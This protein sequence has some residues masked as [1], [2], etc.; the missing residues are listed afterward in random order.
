MTIRVL[1]W[2]TTPPRLPVSEA[3]ACPLNVVADTIMP[4][5]EFGGDDHWCGDR[6]GADLDRLPPGPTRSGLSDVR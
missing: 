4:T 1:H 6:R 3:S 5:I 2:T